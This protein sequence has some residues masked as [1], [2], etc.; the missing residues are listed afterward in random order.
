MERVSMLK[1]ET[2]AVRG[3][4]S[5][6]GLLSFAN[7]FLSNCK[8]YYD[9]NIECLVNFNLVN[10]TG[11]YDKERKDTQNIWEYYFEN[12][13][14]GQPDQVVD[15]IGEYEYSY[16]FDHSDIR[17]RQICKA[18]INK[19]LHIKKEILIEVDEFYHHHKLQNTIGVHYRGTDITIHH[20][21]VDIQRYF[22]E[23]DKILH[24][25]EKVFL[26]SDEYQTINIF[27]DKYKDALITTQSITLS[28]NCDIP[29]YKQIGEG[30]YQKGKDVLIESL[31]LSKTAF[32]IK[33]RSNVSNFSLLFNPDLRF[34]NLACDTPSR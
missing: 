28:D 20:P 22:N 17:K 34:I 31:L 15:W 23:I 9:Q 4:E 24:R 2:I 33:S 8:H 13:F 6:R 16:T 30:G 1:V 7:Q 19:H 5:E 32:L 12:N 3:N 11:Y 10:K 29:S 27:R 21:K 25:F 14:I 18:L 26:C